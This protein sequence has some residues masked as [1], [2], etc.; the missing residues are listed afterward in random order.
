MEDSVCAA[1][2]LERIDGD[3]SF[4]AELLELFRADYPE[5]IR[6][7]R[8][9]LVNDDAMGLQR[10]AHGLKGALK[11]LAAPAAANLAAELEAM[12][13]SGDTTLAISKMM[14]L[15]GEVERVVEALEALCMETAK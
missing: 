10:A 8:E 13:K 12:G 11:N 14:E 1:E 9:V 15:E 3:R 2:L 6:K 7:C 4:L 5:Q